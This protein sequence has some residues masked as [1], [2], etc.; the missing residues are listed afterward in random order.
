VNAH[1]TT[2]WAAAALAAGIILGAGTV[3]AAQD[4]P[5]PAP[6]PTPLPVLMGAGHDTLRA[7]AAALTE[8]MTHLLEG[9]QAAAPGGGRRAGPALPG[10]RM[11][12]RRAEW[13]RDSVDKYR[14]EPFDVAGAAGAMHVR[15]TMLSRRARRN[16]ALR[17]TWQ[18]WDA[19]V[20]ILDRI[21]KLLAGEKV[22][23]PSP[24]APRPLPP[25][26]PSPSPSPR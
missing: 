16:E 17:H 23:T 2:R 22:T 24:H 15:A 12:R 4:A 6:A 26:A 18:D 9:T 21:R 14:A 5:A 19:A 1:A 3:R 8:E 20:D 10:I 25:R 13:F 11:L 7:L